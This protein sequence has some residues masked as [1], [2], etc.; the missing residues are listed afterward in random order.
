MAATDSPRRKTFTV[1]LGAEAVAASTA[2]VLVDLSDTTNFPHNDT[3]WINLLGLILNTE[4]HSDGVFDIWVGSI[5]E[6]DADNGS[7]EWFKVFHLEH[8]ANTTDSTDRFAEVV[9]FTL[10]GANPDGINCKVNSGGT[11]F[12]YLL[13]NQ[14]QA[15]SDNWQTDTGL[16]SPAGAASGATGK[17]GAGDIVVWV[18]EVSDAGTLDFSLTAIYEAH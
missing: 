3:N 13:S 12:V 11:G 17:P 6:V 16:A 1:H 5:Y 10:G 4:K 18:E 2:Y 14:E 15:G 9:D 7:A 8:V